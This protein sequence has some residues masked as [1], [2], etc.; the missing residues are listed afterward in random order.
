MISCILFER[1]YRATG[2]TGK[3]VCPSL[4]HSHEALPNLK[5]VQA[6]SRVSLIGSFN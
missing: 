5:R 6:T 1:F 3:I 2:A 4:E